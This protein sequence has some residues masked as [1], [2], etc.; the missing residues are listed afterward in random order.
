[1]AFPEE[2]YAPIALEVSMDW[3]LKQANK[4]AE[5]E[6]KNVSDFENDDESNG[7]SLLRME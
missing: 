3:R 7:R 1:V 5:R 2:T 4:L 6:Y